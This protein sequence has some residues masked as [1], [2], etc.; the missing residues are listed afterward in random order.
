MPLLS[1]N[2]LT[3]DAVQRQEEFYLKLERERDTA[4][5]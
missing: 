4:N 2:M 5:A 1:S 3:F